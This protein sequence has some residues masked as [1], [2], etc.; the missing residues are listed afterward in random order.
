MNKVD[1]MRGL[2]GGLGKYIEWQHVTNSRSK[3]SPRQGIGQILVF[4]RRLN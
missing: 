3:L 2:N 1:R 4:Y